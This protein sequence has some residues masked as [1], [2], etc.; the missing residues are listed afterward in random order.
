MTRKKRENR[1]S[2]RFEMKTTGWIVL[3][4]MAFSSV[5]YAQ[6]KPT[7]TSEND[8]RVLDFEG[9]VIETSFLKPDATLIEGELRKSTNS[10]LKE[11]TDF[12]P[13]VVKSAENL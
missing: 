9:D 4:L 5:A 1:A 12:I 8:E 11:R 13:E 10:L 7:K 6:V 2:R 3:I